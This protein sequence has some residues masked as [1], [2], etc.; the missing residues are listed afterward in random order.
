M[1]KI[2]KGQGIVLK[3]G[4][5]QLPDDRSTRE[6]FVAIIEFP[7]GPPDLPID[8]VWK[9]RLVTVALAEASK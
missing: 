5:M 4:W 8:A 6:R 7:E 9:R 3:V 2:E 1:S